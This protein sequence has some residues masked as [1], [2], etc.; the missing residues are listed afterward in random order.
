MTLAEK[1]YQKSLALPEDAARE[2]LDFIEFL[3]ERYGAKESAIAAVAALDEE[4]R[5]KALDYL[6][7]L[8]IDW[9]GK[10]IPDRDE[11]YDEAR[12]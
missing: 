1:I 11:L 6:A 9:G 7:T 3:A 12:D 4:S 8:R 10:P 5:Q 2:A